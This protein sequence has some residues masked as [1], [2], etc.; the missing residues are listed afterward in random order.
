MATQHCIHGE[1]NCNR[2][3][4]N[5]VEAPTIHL[6]LILDVSPSMDV[7]WPQTLSGLNEYFDTLRKDQAAEGQPYRVTMTTFSKNV[8]TLYDNVVLDVI[9]RFTEDNLSPYGWGTALWDAVGETVTKIETTEPV[10]VVVLTDGDENSSSIWDRQ[11]VSTLMDAREKM[12][13]YTYAYLGVTKE[14]WANST[15]MGAGMLRNSANTVASDYGIGTYTKLAAATTS[16]TRGMRSMKSAGL[17]ANHMNIASFW[18]VTPT[19]IT[20]EDL[21]AVSVTTTGGKAILSK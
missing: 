14:A 19:Q 7:R 4:M 13:N 15:A 9:P 12:G 5:E 3:A 11:K 18:S 10:L 16:Y 8:T 21:D 1:E 2:C 6:H 20:D 17:E